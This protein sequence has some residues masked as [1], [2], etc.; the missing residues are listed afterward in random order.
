VHIQSNKA[1]LRAEDVKTRILIY[2]LFPFQAQRPEQS[3]MQALESLNDNQVRTVFN[4]YIATE[5][6]SDL[7]KLNLL[8][9]VWF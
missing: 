4:S 1:D 6:F 3:V 8:M 5:R 2:S 7:A 9:V